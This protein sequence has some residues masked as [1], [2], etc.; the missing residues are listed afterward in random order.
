MGRRGERERKG[1][2]GEGR[3]ERRRQMVHYSNHT[4]YLM[5]ADSL[6]TVYLMLAD[7]AK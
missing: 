4:V 5:L 7:Q 2:G 6:N 1:E 3:G